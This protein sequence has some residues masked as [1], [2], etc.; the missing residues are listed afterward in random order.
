[1]KLRRC[2]GRLVALGQAW[3]EFE[4]RPSPGR[5][6]RIGRTGLAAPRLRFACAPFVHHNFKCLRKGQALKKKAEAEV[7]AV[8]HGSVFPRLSSPT[9][10]GKPAVVLLNG[11]EVFINHD[12]GFRLSPSPSSIKRGRSLCKVFSLSLFVAMQM[13]DQPRPATERKEGGREGGRR[14][15]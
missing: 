1:M 6:F 4:W 12:F 14:S 8:P 13:F 2:R 9:A 7:K 11:H 10:V 3:P 5:R 15:R